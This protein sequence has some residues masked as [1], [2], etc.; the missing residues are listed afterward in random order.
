MD[1]SVAILRKLKKLWV[2][3]DSCDDLVDTLRGF[4]QKVGDQFLLLLNAFGLAYF[5]CFTSFQVVKVLC[6]MYLI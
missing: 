1:K 3:L 4:R 2:H 6:Y 5:L